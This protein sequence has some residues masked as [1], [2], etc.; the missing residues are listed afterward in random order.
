M[1]MQADLGV[2]CSN[3]NKAGLDFSYVG[4]HVAYTDNDILYKWYT[5]IGFT[6]L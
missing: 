3:M 1:F 2:C 6:H 5:V 4:A